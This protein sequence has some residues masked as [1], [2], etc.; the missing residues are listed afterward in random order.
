MRNRL[1]WLSLASLLCLPA[2]AAQATVRGGDR[3]VDFSLKDRS[4]KTVKLSDLRGNVVVMSFWASWCVPCR[5]ELPALDGYARK[6]AAE[7]K[8][9]VFLAINYDD[10]RDNAERFLAKV[11]ISAMQVL[12][13]P[14]KTTVKTYDPEPIPGSFVIDAKGIVKLF[15]GGWDDDGSLGPIARAVEALSP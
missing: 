7:N 8:K 3:S 10:N 14:Q 2:G 1:A 13:D 4:G 6:L 9:V 5:K 15:H 11:K 12:F